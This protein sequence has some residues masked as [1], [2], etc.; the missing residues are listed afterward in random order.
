M[1]ASNNNSYIPEELYQLL[2]TRV[3]LNDLVAFDLHHL[4]HTLEK[5]TRC[6]ISFI[7]P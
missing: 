6:E 1:E 4:T 3:T 7:T 5:K 2:S